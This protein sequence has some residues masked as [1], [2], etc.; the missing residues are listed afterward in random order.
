MKTMFEAAFISEKVFNTL[1][2]GNDFIIIFS[3]QEVLLLKSPENG[4]LTFPV[5][6]D[7][8]QLPENDIMLYLGELSGRRCFGTAVEFLPEILPEKMCRYSCRSALFELPENLQNALCRAKML[9]NWKRSHRFCGACGNGLVYSKTDIALFC[10]ECK[11]RYYPQISPAI[12][13]AIT[14]NNGNELLLAH[15]R[16]FEDGFYSLIAGFVEAG[17]SVESAVHREVM[18][19]CGIKI[20]NLKY[21]TSQAWPFPN[22]LMLA[23]TAEYDS[24]TPAVDGV[25]LTDLGWF[26]ADNHPKLPRPGS[27]AYRVI[28]QIFYQII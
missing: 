23:F 12:I 27:V 28:R 26:T 5:L 2:S 16:N 3:S 8:T 4:N 11:N 17:E 1:P 18:E 9:I 6:S 7:F 21:V 22:S 19:E 15:N 10:P 24:G 14:R 20:R 13:V 25:E